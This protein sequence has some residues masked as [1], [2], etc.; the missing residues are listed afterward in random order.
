VW[1]LFLF[2][3]PLHRGMDIAHRETDMSLS[4]SQTF[5][6]RVEWD[7]TRSANAVW[8][9]ANELTDESTINRRRWPDGLQLR[10]A[11]HLVIIIFI[12][13]LFF[14]PGSIDPRG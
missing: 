7:T 3:T 13:F 10:F 6:T 14:T 8:M 9:H 4:L 5:D 2:T 11:L 1:C 12:T